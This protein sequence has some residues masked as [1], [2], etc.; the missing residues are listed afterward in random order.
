M[1][2]RLTDDLKIANHGILGLDVAEEYF[3]TIARVQQDSLDRVSNVE[4]IVSLVFHSGTASARIC[5]SR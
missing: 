1:L 4:Q 2:D 5:F 3:S